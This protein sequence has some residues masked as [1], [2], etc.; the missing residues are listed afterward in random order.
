[1]YL[2]K[3]IKLIITEV[4][5]AHNITPERLM[6]KRKTK[7]SVYARQECCA[8]LR[9]E[10]DLSYHEIGEY[11]KVDHS[12]VIYGQKAALA[13]GLRSLKQTNKSTLDKPLDICNT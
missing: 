5:Q 8:R 6:L 13:R 1:M 11:L 4:C 3:Q 12:T 10:T 9:Q 2:P 7:S